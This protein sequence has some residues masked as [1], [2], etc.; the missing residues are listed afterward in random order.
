MRRRLFATGALAAIGLP[1]F[2]QTELSALER[3]RQR[4]RLSVAVYKDMPPFS[5]DG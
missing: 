3:L 4:R 1:A 5:A 2:A